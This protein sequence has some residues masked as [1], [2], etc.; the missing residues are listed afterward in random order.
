MDIPRRKGFYII[1][2]CKVCSPFCLSHTFSQ[3][4]GCLLWHQDSLSSRCSPWAP[5]P[6]VPVSHLSHRPGPGALQLLHPLPVDPAGSQIHPHPALGHEGIT[7]AVLPQVST[8][9]L[10]L[11][12]L[13]PCATATTGTSCPLSLPSCT[14]PQQLSLHPASLHPHSTDIH[15]GVRTKNSSGDQFLS[16]CLK[17]LIYYFFFPT[18]IKELK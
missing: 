17:E 8:C 14:S 2:H 12:P 15:R 3:R 4:T 7:L 10:P 1:L 5:A 16:H 13:S 6:P 11:P 9:H 18:R